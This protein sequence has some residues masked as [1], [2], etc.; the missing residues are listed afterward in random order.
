MNIE[1]GTGIFNLINIMYWAAMAVIILVEAATF[2]VLWRR[3][4]NH[5]WTMGYFTV[6]LAGVPLL[7]IGAWD[8]NTWVG[9]FFAVGISG[10]VKVGYESARQSW[11]ARKLREASDATDYRC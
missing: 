6:F 7:M 1:A 9:L 2:G 4:E 8:V 3:R 11:E 5:R 10:A